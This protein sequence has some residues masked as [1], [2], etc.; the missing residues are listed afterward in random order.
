MIRFVGLIVMLVSMTANAA[1]IR[2]PTGVNVDASGPTSLTIRF[3]DSAGAAFTT[4]EALFCFA[5]E[6]DGRCAPGS[7]LG[8][9]PIP[10][11]LSSG[12]DA[13][14][15]LTDVMTIPYSV[16]RRALS[17]AQ[18][19]EF[20]D[21]F[22][23]R[24]FSPVGG[25]D[26]GAGPGI[27]VYVPITCRLTAGIARS[28]LSLTRVHVYGEEGQA[29]VDLV[30]LSASNLESGR[31]VADVRVTGTGILS[32]WWEVRMPGDPEFDEVDL[33]PPASLPQIDRG[34]QQRFLR[35]KRF[36]V[37]VPLDGRIVL[38]GPAYSELPRARS[39]AHD[40]L[41]RFDVSQDREALSSLDVDGERQ[42][43]YSGAAA[44]FAIRPLEYYVPA[45]MAKANDDLLSP[46]LQ[47]VDGAALVAWVASASSDAV[48]EISVGEAEPFRM[49]V[50]ASKGIAEL[51]GHLALDASVP[52]YIRLFDREGRPM[53]AAIAV[54]R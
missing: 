12:T 22:Y 9:L 36:R 20:S 30:R 18:Q 41:L 29:N 47:T 31:V 27:D 23:V 43:L 19:G 35:V 1:M 39:G 37:Q 26:I 53:S 50:P 10:T 8:R 16:T 44:G 42:Q 13:R 34:R 5:L 3:T 40:V 28:P 17:R 11:D 52:L 45:S 7:I 32:G 4:T 25:A 2:N 49:L 33:L 14:R 51:P 46:Y 24:R 54:R 21:F 15:A 38:E 48:I 6:A